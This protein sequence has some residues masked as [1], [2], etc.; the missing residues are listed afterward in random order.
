MNVFN[1]RYIVFL[2]DSKLKDHDGK[3]FASY[4]AAKEFVVD[5][6]NEKYADKAVIGL[7][8]LEPNRQEMHIS[9]IDTVGFKGDKKSASQLQLFQ[10]S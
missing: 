9:H 2:I 1:L 10:P 3:V 5:M 6:I 7:F 4:S 8:Y